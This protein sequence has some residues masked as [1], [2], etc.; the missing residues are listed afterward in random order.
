MVSRAQLGIGSWTY[1]ISLSLL[2]RGAQL[3]LNKDGRV[4]LVEHRG[5]KLAYFDKIDTD[6]EGRHRGRNEGRRSPPMTNYEK[7]RMT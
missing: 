4:S 1:V 2:V 6:K 5:G 7:W 3:D